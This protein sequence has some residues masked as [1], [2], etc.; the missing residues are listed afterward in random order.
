MSLPQDGA[1]RIDISSAITD[2]TW[3]APNLYTPQVDG[4]LAVLIESGRC[5]IQRNGTY[6][7]SAGSYDSTDVF[8]LRVFLPVIAGATYEIFVRGTLKEAI[9]Y[10]CLGNV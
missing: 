7:L 5:I 2:T 1:A 6:G 4:W 10:P 9:L 3:T 8:D